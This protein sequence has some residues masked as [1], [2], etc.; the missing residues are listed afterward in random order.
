MKG[1]LSLEI[2]LGRFGR[3]PPI[4]GAGSYVT[5]SRAISM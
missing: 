1:S 2:T 3:N 5:L 4:N